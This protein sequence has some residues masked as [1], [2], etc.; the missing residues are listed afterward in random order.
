[1]CRN[2][3]HQ[4]RIF[5]PNER[6]R[7]YVG[8]MELIFGQIH[9]IDAIH[10]FPGLFALHSVNLLLIKDKKIQPDLWRILALAAPA[11]RRMG[12]P[13]PLYQSEGHRARYGY[14]QFQIC[15]LTVTRV[16]RKGTMWRRRRSPQQEKVEFRVLVI[17]RV[18]PCST[19]QS[20]ARPHV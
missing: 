13:D 2:P 15:P 5:A 9:W 14:F 18:N 1:M 17:C 19:F 11:L 20:A 10:Q 16:R 7:S 8:L 12:V 6:V 3:T 4:M